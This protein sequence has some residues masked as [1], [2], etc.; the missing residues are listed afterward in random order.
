[1]KY[2]NEKEF[3]LSGILNWHNLGYTGKDVKIANMETCNVDAWYFKK[4]VNDPFDNGREGQ[5]NSHGNQTLNVIHQ[6][7]PD[8]EFY[9]LPRGGSYSS[10]SVTG[11]LIEKSLPYMISEGI[12]LV[13]ASVGGTN[14]KILNEAILNVQKHGTTFV[15]SAG[16][17][18]DRGAS[19]YAKS[20]VWIAIGAVV[21]N[22]RNE[23]K[24]TTYSS[25][26]EEVDFVQFS[27]IYVNDVRKGYEDRVIYR[28]GTSFS[29]PLLV[30]MLALVQQFFYEKTGQYLNQDKLYQFMVDNSIDLGDVG[31]DKEYGHGLF[32]L[33]NPEDIDIEKYI[34]GDFIKIPENDKDESNNSQRKIFKANIESQLLDPGHFVIPFRG[35]FE[36]E[37]A[38]E[39]NWGRD[40][41]GKVWAEAILPASKRRKISVRQDSKDIVVEILE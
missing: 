34:E 29:S 6:V 25:I 20:G 15:S 35:L 33:P 32:V 30:G 31:K 40:E 38:E 39:I 8:A 28:S 22:V 12:H 2:I 26:D 18:G 7:A 13:S 4:Q 19:P 37:N 23:I 9:T 41:K 16:N 1:M 5:E 11:N 27:E 24:L 36:A 17:S 3:E 10:K 21:L 14:N